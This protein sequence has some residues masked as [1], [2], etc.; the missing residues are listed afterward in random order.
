MSTEMVPSRES[1]SCVV[2]SAVVEPTMDWQLKKSLKVKVGHVMESLRGAAGGG[3]PNWQS[4][5]HSIEKWTALLD[6]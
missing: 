4:V 6:T 2:G 5:E 3:I 1:E